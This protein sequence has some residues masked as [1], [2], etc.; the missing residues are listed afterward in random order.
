MNFVFVMWLCQDEL[1]KELKSILF[2]YFWTLL[3]H[4]K[5]NASFQVCTAIACVFFITYWW[6]QF[7]TKQ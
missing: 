1:N 3:P 4:K 2:T 6:E 5:G 7:A